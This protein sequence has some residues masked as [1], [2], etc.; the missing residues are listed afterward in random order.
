[1]AKIDTKATFDPKKVL[2]SDAKTGEIPE[3]ES[4]IIIEQ[5]SKESMVSKLA[6]YEPMEKQFKKFTYLAE[7]PG[8]YWVGEGEKIQVDSAKWLEMEMRA[9]KIGVILPVSKEF[10]NYT[11]ADFFTQ[12]RPHLEEAIKDKIDKTVFFGADDSP[13]G[14][15]ASVYEKAKAKGNVLTATADTYDD[16]NNLIA[17]IE[18]GDHEAQAFVTTT[19]KNKDLRG[20]R[21]EN[22][23]SI[24]NDA[25]DGV[26]ARVLGLP[27][28]YGNKKSFDKSKAEALTGNF[29]FLRYGIPKG[30]EYTISEDA[31]LTTVTGEDGKPINLFERDLIALKVTMDFGFMVIKDDAFAAL[32]PAAPK[33]GE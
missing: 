25:R 18:A 7:G 10:L 33:A 2:L 3:S 31:T 19:S 24:F 20:A 4:E 27:V 5:I 30:L 12:I 13:W 6:K 26:T 32:E 14:A 17:L 8:A 29:D 16:I 9:H 28:V 15:G 1:M 23:N 21:D 22:K 11:V